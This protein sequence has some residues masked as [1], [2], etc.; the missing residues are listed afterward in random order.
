[1]ARKI[2]HCDKGTTDTCVG[3][4]RGSSSGY[5]MWAFITFLNAVTSSAAPFLGDG[6]G[7]A[8]EFASTFLVILP[9]EEE[10]EERESW[11]ESSFISVSMLFS[12]YHVQYNS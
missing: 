9:L 1:M 4:L 3:E 10:E 7:S 8:G 12:G 6:L 11:V 5:E 2:F